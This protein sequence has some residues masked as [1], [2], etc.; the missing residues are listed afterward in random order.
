MVF[1]KYIQKIS[2][3]V[4]FGKLIDLSAQTHRKY[5]FWKSMKKNLI[6]L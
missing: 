2:F 3:S 1:E 4:Q 5:T 6:E